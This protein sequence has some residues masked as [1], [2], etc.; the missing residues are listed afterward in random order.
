[1]KIS[2]IYKSEYFG[3]LIRL[4][5]GLVFIYASISKIINPLDFSID[6]Q[7]YRI[8][9]DS[10]TNLVA[11]I[12]PWLEL[13]CGLFIIFGILSR[14]SAAAIA[15][16]MSVFIIALISAL[17]RGLDINCGCFNPGDTADKVGIVKIIEDLFYLAM[18]LYCYFF[19][20]QRLTIVKLLNIITQKSRK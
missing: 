11:I 1:M 15:F 12:L 6:I 3:L 14:V 20:P 10:L 18:A 16:L 8:L 19:P 13:Y 4:I 17:I 2:Q 5:L 7:N 9:P